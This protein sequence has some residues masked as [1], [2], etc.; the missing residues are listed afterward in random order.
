MSRTAGVAATL[1]ASLVALCG[2][3]A[4]ET[5][6][7][8]DR[9]SQAPST[10]APSTASAAVSV[11][12]SVAAI[13][14]GHFSPSDQDGT[15]VELR[16]DTYESMTYDQGTDPLTKRA[17]VY[18]PHGYDAGTQ[19]DVFYL[20]HGGWGNEASTLGT[21]ANPSEFK[22]VLDNAI[23]AGEMEPLIVV[24]PTYNNTSP[25]DSASF[26]LALSL[27]ENYHNE[28][29][30]DLIP[31]VEGEYS[32]FADG[33]SAEALMASRDHRGF[34][35]F[36][37]GAVVTWRTFQ[38]GLDYFRYFLPMSCGTSL[39][40]EN[41]LAAAD[42]RDPGD[43]SVWVITGTEDFAYPYDEQRVELMRDSPSFGEVGDGGVENF[44][45]TVKDGYS[46]DGTAAMEYTYNGMRQFWGS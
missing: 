15:L 37:M 26:G 3:T 21:P 2:C 20:M 7:A 46:H 1:L 23:A 35:G 38:H 43:Y 44:A 10:V 41:I 33:T 17:I 42:T 4:G 34:G 39:D 22:N 40:M 30:N 19:Y 6:I 14:A 36:S 29:L 5:P 24:A 27:N 13:P 32:T 8:A 16:Y 9:E 18:L 25:E 11:A 12:P 45:F 28:L 31:A